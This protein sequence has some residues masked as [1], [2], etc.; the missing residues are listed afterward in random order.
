MENKNLIVIMAVAAV[1]LVVLVSAL[2]TRVQ[3]P[4]PVDQVD[5]DEQPRLDAVI[6]QCEREWYNTEYFKTNCKSLGLK[7]CEKYPTQC[8]RMDNILRLA[9]MEKSGASERDRN[10]LRDQLRQRLR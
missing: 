3:P 7:M 1:S 8:T 6:G 9:E 2:P 4:K 5:P 10:E